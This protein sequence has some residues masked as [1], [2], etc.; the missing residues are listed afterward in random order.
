MIGGEGPCVPE[1]EGDGQRILVAQ[2]VAGIEIESREQD[3]V[4]VPGSRVDAQMKDRVARVRFRD[5]AAMLLPPPC[6]LYAL[7]VARMRQDIAT[8]KPE[9][10]GPN[11]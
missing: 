7:G 3:I 5:D 4:A 6:L 8:P 1:I 11:Q 9:P 10:Q 2:G